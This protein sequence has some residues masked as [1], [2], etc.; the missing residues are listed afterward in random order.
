M[1]QNEGGEKNDTSLK[2]SDNSL[3][4]ISRGSRPGTSERIAKL[5]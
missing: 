2:I 3:K 4:K 1:A 5:H